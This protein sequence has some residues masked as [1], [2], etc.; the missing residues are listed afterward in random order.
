MFTRHRVKSS[1]TSLPVGLVNSLKIYIKS[2]NNRHRP[3]ISALTPHCGLSTTLGSQLQLRLP[4]IQT[5]IY[6]CFIKYI[7]HNNYRF[8]KSRFK[9]P[10]LNLN[11]CIILY[12]EYKSTSNKM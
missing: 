1:Q 11:N 12:Y 5:E 9:T 7:F 8:L 10:P 4:G 3:H 6:Y 2:I